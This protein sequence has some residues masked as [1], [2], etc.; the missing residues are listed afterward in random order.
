MKR[1]RPAT[2]D[3]AFAEIQKKRSLPAIPEP[4]QT[5]HAASVR[6][7]PGDSLWKI[8]ERNLGNGAR[9]RELAAMNPEISDPNVIEV[10]EWIR[11][12]A[13]DSQ[14]AKQVV[15]RAGDTLWNVA[16]TQFGDARAFA[17]I[18]HANP[19]LRTADL[20][21]PGQTLVLPDTCAVAR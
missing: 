11:L 7:A 10:G 8:A 6:V 1:A 19:Q 20:I 13:G 5:D 16:Q 2:D 21:Y 9:W 3:L 18:A 12:S 14:N 15:V 4:K 17:C